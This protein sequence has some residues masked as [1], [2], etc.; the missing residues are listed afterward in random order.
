M[1]AE[2]EHGVGI[3]I[4]EITP[5]DASVW[6]ATVP[7]LPWT[8]LRYV[9]TY[10]KEMSDGR[11]ALNGETVILSRSGKLLDGRKRLRACLESGTSFPC[12]LVQG[13]DEE[14]LQTIDAL[15]PR[16]AGDILF[17]RH[18]RHHRVLAAVLNVV[19]RYY[20]QYHKG[21]PTGTRSVARDTLFA[22]DIRPEIRDSVE[23]TADF[24]AMGAHVVAAAVHHLASRIDP[25]RA[26]EFFDRILHGPEVSDD[27]AYLLRNA[28]Q[29][30]KRAPQEL[31]L[32]LTI[33]AWNSYHA[34]RPLKYLRWRTEGA[35]PQKFPVLAALAVEDGDDLENRRVWNPDVR[36]D[37]RDLDIKVETITPAAAEELFNGRAQNRNVVS[38]VVEKYAHDM[39]AGRW[40]LNGQTIKI[41]KSGR[42]LDGQHRCTAAVKTG[43]AFR[44]IVVRGLP[45]EVFDTLDVG[46]SR[47]LGQVLSDRGEKSGFALAA[48][49]HKLWLYEEGT[50]TL[51]TRRGS[52][53]ELIQVLENNPDLRRSVHLCVSKGR[54]MVPGS[55][56]VVTHYLAAKVD[57]PKADEFIV[58][59]GEGANLSKDS[60]VLALRE[61]L[62]KNQWNQRKRLG[63]V[64]K[65]A[66]TIKAM[67][68]HLEGRPIRLLVWRHGS[69][70]PFPRVLRT[71]ESSGM[72]AVGGR[73]PNAQISAPRK[74]RTGESV[75][76]PAPV[77]ARVVSVDATSA[78][79]PV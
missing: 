28:F 72:Q 21:A 52:H 11:W 53:A 33:R 6:L 45:D 31:M 2:N 78:L 27:P 37:P 62:R 42:L 76:P 13:I 60:P 50:P 10:A 7:P 39:E 23:R 59:L 64:D 1:A 68:A 79:A 24:R 41:S 14:G 25:A 30:S 55:A 8:A 70:E 12:V 63:E 15:R 36:V 54:N 17:I 43:I 49:L 75:T 48:A 29:N 9:R 5:K 66:I 32:A 51:H 26:D 34:D 40:A 57:A 20:R 35:A 18:E 74:P 47:S 73:M 56:G 46:Q 19:V 16:S 65:W 61:L 38:R 4:R 58:S 22:L 71:Q 77:E 44:A 69:N 3:S 67:N